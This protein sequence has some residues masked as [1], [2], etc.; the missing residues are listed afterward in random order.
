MNFSR[1]FYLFYFGVQLYGIKFMLSDGQFLLRRATSFYAKIISLSWIIS[2]I[3]ALLFI[4]ASI[5]RTLFVF[6]VGYF[7]FSSA[8]D[9]FFIWSNS[10]LVVYWIGF[11]GTY[12]RYLQKTYNRHIKLRNLTRLN[13]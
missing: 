9:R 1:I 7:F 4:I 8:G 6:K 11:F 5:F 2:T 3:V 12:L 10:Y 13:Q